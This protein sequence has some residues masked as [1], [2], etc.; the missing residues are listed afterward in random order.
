MKLRGN[1]RSWWGEKEEANDANTVLVYE[2]LKKCLIKKEMK[3]FLTNVEMIMFS[4]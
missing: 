4:A 3:R 2:I 1:G